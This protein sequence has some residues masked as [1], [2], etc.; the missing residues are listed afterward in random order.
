MMHSSAST[1]EETRSVVRR[2]KK[3]SI[4]PQNNSLFCD[5]CQ[6]YVSSDI[7]MNTHIQ[8][9]R[10]IELEKLQKKQM[11]TATKSLYVRG[12]PSGSTS[13]QIA[14][15]FTGFG[16]V[17]KIVLEKEHGYYAIV[18][19]NDE[20]TVQS[21]LSLPLVVMNGSRLT[22]KSRQLKGLPPKRKT[23]PNEQNSARNDTNSSV[24]ATGSNDLLERM[25]ECSNMTEEMNFLTNELSL[26]SED[27]LQRHSVCREIENILRMN[28]F[29]VCSVHPFGSSV[30]GL[31]S[32]GCDLDIFLNLESDGTLNGLPFA[33]KDLLCDVPDFQNGPCTPS[34][35]PPL[36]NGGVSGPDV[37]EVVDGSMDPAADQPVLQLVRKISDL[38]YTNSDVFSRV[39]HISNARCPVV[40]FIH[41]QSGLKCDLSI[42]NRLALCNTVLLKCLLNSD[43]R[44]RPLIASV[45][46]WAKLSEVAGQS[47]TGSKLT[48]YALTMVVVFYLQ[49]ISPPVLPP[50]Q[51]LSHLAEKPC[52][53]DGW[54]CAFTTDLS[55]IP[56][57]EISC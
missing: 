47:N 50:I 9:K 25:K 1:T 14:Q 36:P 22:I 12:Y 28:L 17:D 54:D 27:I 46:H 51:E 34:A 15:F 30:S 11:S 3:M 6:V 55:K 8:G 45:R 48:N 31:G 24:D 10:H 32:K 42:N 44:I 21:I 35:A 49:N 5:I 41:V 18:E 38:L 37:G 23:Q 57:T 20:S 40:K 7:V 52:M 19:F 2:L 39:I 16:K 26:S 33:A 43:D 13:N 56:R 29:P 4:A 53:V